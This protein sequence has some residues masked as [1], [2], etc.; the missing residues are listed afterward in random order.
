MRGVSCIPHGRVEQHDEA[1]VIVPVRG[2]SCIIT[3]FFPSSM[4][5]V[6]VPVRGVSCIPSFEIGNSDYNKVIVPVRGVSC[7]IFILI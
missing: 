2:V 3:L 5:A 4:R 6:I 1:H 7:I